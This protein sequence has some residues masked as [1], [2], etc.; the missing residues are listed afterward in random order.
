MSIGARLDLGRKKAE[1]LLEDSLLGAE[2]SARGLVVVERK[3]TS[4]VNREMS[5]L[6]LLYP[7]L[8]SYPEA[9]KKG[10]ISPESPKHAITLK[11]HGS[12]QDT[13]LSSSTKY[14]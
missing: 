14:D 6:A 4:K 3:V 5:P 11:L 10:Y 9:S 7:S 12:S 13:R 8:G 1:D 2:E